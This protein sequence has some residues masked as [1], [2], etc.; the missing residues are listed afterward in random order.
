[1]KKETSRYSS[2]VAVIL[3][4]LA[5][6][7]SPR[8]FC[9][10]ALEVF[11]FFQVNFQQFLETQ[12]TEN[13]AFNFSVVDENDRNS[14]SA[15]QINLFFRKE[16]NS[17]FT[18]WL[19]FEFTNSFSSERNWGAFNLEEAWIKYHHSDRL[20]IKA[21][22]L[23]PV[24]NNLNEVKNR[25]PYLP[26]IIRPPVYETSLSEILPLSDFVPQRAYLQVYGVQ[27][28]GSANLDY[29]VYV[30]NSEDEHI[31]TVASGSQQTGLDTTN[32]LLVGTRLGMRFGR[33][34]AGVSATYDRDNQNPSGLGDV[35]RYR[36]GADL[37]FSVGAL[38]F[39]GETIFVQHD[40]DMPGISLDKRF[41]YGTVL[42]DFNERMFGYVSYNY[43][44]DDFK[45]G[46]RDGMDAYLVG[47]GYR[48]TDL[49]IL[50]AQFSK[51][52]ADEDDAPP[53]ASLPVPVDFKFDATWYSV[54]F[55][56]F[57]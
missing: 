27:E 57:F 11:G 15:Q 8:A 38:T 22:L 43:G 29:A 42:C 17:S 54:A 23:I 37:S 51:I 16:L 47:G 26:Y 30:G 13:P 33:C 14:F 34:K 24:F 10:E 4:A 40:L 50:K 12:R 6:T 3:L 44:E 55:S 48:I 7:P 45:F 46:L 32:F 56:V 53:D 31:N 35:K 2:R 39:E 9:Q 36:F 25:M 18:A 28:M 21:G 49:L 1:M 19:N 52:S 41:H 5:C 20:K